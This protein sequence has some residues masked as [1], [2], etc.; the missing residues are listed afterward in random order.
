L[1]SDVGFSETVRVRPLSEYLL[2]KLGKGTVW[3]YLS[4]RKYTILTL[5]NLESTNPSGF[6]YTVVYKDSD[7]RVW[8]K[9][10][11]EW[12]DKFTYDSS[13]EENLA[14]EAE[15]LAKVLCVRDGKD[16]DDCYDTF[17]R[18]DY[19]AEPHIT[20]VWEH[21]LQDAYNFLELKRELNY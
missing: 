21:Y 2:W 17:D 9:S 1:F 20:Y 12:M 14:D 15:K 5:T 19:N 8:S 11:Y 18:G 6:P 4:I 13:Y 7:G 10:V 16:V 3:N